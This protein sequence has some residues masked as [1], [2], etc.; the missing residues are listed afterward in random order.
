MSWHLLGEYEL[1]YEIVEEFRKTQTV[2]SSYDYEY[3]ELL[4]YQNMIL[5]DGSKF[6]AALAHLER[7]ESDICDELS[8]LETK[9]EVN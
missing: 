3:S 7:H 4:L 1:A 6:A 5:A 8:V 9:G 2:K